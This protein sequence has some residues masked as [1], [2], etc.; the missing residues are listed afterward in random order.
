MGVNVDSIGIPGLPIFDIFS[1]KPNCHILSYAKLIW[2]DVEGKVL[3]LVMIRLNIL[4]KSMQYSVISAYN[5][6]VSR[7]KGNIPKF[8]N[9]LVSNP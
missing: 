8:M 1:R 6:A 3:Y 9:Q 4:L 2:D 7:T 5:R